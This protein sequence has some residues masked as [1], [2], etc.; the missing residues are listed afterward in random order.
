MSLMSSMSEGYNAD[1]SDNLEPVLNRSSCVWGTNT[2]TVLTLASWL[3]S[4]KLDI[5]VTFPQI[6][7]NRDKCYVGLL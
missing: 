5:A 7:V 3:N 4:D 6:V 2:N 1:G